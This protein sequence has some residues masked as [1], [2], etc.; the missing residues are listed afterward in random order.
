[1]YHWLNFKI[2]LKGSEICS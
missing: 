1:M 2:L